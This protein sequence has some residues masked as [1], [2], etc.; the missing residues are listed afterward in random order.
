[1]IRWT[2]VTVLLLLGLGCSSEPNLLPEAAPCKFML[3]AIDGT[4]LGEQ[5]QV[6]D[7]DGQVAV[8]VELEVASLSLDKFDLA[9]RPIQEP[10]LWEL[11]LC[12]VDRNSEKDKLHPVASL[13]FDDPSIRTMNLQVSSDLIPQSARPESFASEKAGVMRYFGSLNVAGIHHV[14]GRHEFALR[15]FPTADKIM[16]MPVTRLMGSP[17]PLHYFH[18][19]FQLE[20]KD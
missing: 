14:T 17:V 12:I 1:M 11:D 13:I 7:G 18:A 5:I 15:L 20:G 16:A 10:R 3:L 9:G 4:P 19:E 6:A 2:G 8:F